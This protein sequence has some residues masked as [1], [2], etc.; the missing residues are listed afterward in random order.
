MMF[1]EVRGHY[2]KLEPSASL[3]SEGLPHPTA[4]PRQLP[5]ADA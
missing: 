4:Q 5:A 2:S 1:L 3:G